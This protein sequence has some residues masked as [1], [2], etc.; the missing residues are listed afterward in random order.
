VCLHP[1][2]PASQ[3]AD[4]T[5]VPGAVWPGQSSRRPRAYAAS[6]TAAAAQSVL[7]L[8]SC[9]CK[10]DAHNG[11]AGQRARQTGQKK[12][13]ELLCVPWQQWA[14]GG[15]LSIF[16][17]THTLSLPPPPSLALQVIQGRRPTTLSTFVLQAPITSP[18]S[19]LAF[20]VLGGGRGVRGAGEPGGE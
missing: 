5:G 12:K 10:Y 1:H 20:F 8:P 18:V 15:R 14:G 6:A 19:P 9:G 13:T 2:T 11:K 7:C 16:A 3:G 17:S 4:E